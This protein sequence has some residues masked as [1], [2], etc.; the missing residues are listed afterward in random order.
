MQ[1]LSSAVTCCSPALPSALPLS[2]YAACD[3]DA[4]SSALRSLSQLSAPD[5]AIIAR[6]A[7]VLV[8]LRA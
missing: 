8:E 5:V 1:A 2:S 3:A 6:A 4:A 7:V